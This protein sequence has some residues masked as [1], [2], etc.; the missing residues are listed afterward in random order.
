ML[1]LPILKENDVR[2]CHL[3][4]DHL[5]NLENFLKTKSFF[6]HFVSI[7]PCNLFFSEA[8]VQKCSVKKVFLKILQNSQKNICARVCNFVK[9]R[10]SDINVFLWILRNFQEQPFPVAVSFPVSE[11]YSESFRTPTMKRFPNIANSF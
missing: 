4:I 8:V 7:F 2:L 1:A 11:V 3:F 9:K 10:V 6:T 5:I